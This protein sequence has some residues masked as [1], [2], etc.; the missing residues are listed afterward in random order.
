MQRFLV[1]LHRASAHSNRIGKLSAAIG[2]CISTPF[3]QDSKPVRALDVG[4]GDMSIAETIAA[5]HP[6]IQWTSTDIHELPAHLADTE[7]WKKYRRFDGSTLILD[8]DL[9]FRIENR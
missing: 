7:K 2:G 1:G 6:N 3:P 4:C 9:R 5:K 8:A